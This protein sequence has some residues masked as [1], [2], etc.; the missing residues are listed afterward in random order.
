M[1]LFSTVERMG[2]TDERQ[3]LD[4]SL[5]EIE[6]ALQSKSFLSGRDEPG[7]GDLAV[8][9][10]LRSIEGLPA[11]DRIMFHDENTDRPLRLWYDRTKSKVTGD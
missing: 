11:H 9:G 2:I 3:A 8:Y 5:V 1:L 10:A 7:L 6:D 4:K